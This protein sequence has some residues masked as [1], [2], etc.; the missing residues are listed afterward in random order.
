MELRSLRS[1]L[2][3]VILLILISVPTSAIKFTVETGD[4]FGTS[5]VSGE[6]M[7]EDSASLDSDI[8]IDDGVVSRVSSARGSGKNTISEGVSG[9]GN[10]VKNTITSDGSF[11]ST[12]TDLAAGVGAISNYQTSLDGSGGSIQTTSSGRENQMTVAGGFS[13]T[14]NMDVSLASVAAQEALTTGTASAL[15][16]PCFSDE[17]VQG[18][19][20]QDMAVSVYGLYSVGDH[21]LGGFGVVAQNAKS[22]GSGGKTPP[23]PINYKL[24]GGMWLNRNPI[25]LSINPE[26]L[27]NLPADSITNGQS[28]ADVVRAQVS[29][30]EDTWDSVVPKTLFSKGTIEGNTFNR[31]LAK[32]GQRD[33]NNVQMWTNGFEDGSSTLAMTVTWSTRAKTVS[34]ADGNSY[35]EIVESD[36]WYNNDYTWRIG[37]DGSQDP[38]S[39][40]IRTI[41][42]H[43]LGHT[44]GLADL[45]PTDK[46]YRPGVWE[47]QTMWG[48]NDGTA[49]WILN[50]GD[51]AGIHK[52]Y[53]S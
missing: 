3:M 15:G 24:S 16:T 2:I 13:G 12:S 6:Y 39:V 9:G 26:D 18:I 20:G 46:N 47:A 25:L 42:L 7:L 27:P 48:Y 29:A 17:L 8:T 1:A 37:T 31:D 38:K 41:A 14:G 19:R 30:A 43:E 5:L 45:Y 21:S 33:G 51:I 52:L 10:S 32:W 40:D 34:G 11:S 4:S 35:S 28:T 50:E 53:G 22:G 44:L 36:C 23:S 49:D